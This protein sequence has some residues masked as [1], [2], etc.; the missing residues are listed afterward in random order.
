M[1]ILRSL[2]ARARGVFAHDRADDELR[3][4]MEA[5]LEMETAEYIRRGMSPAEARRARARGRM[6]V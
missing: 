3:E 5:H 4:E 6:R 2:W 1:R